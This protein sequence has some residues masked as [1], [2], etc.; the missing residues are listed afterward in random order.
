VGWG[1][2]YGAAAHSGRRGRRAVATTF[3]AVYT[4][5]DL[6]NTALGLYRP[7]E[8]VRQDTAIDVIDKLVQAAATGAVFDAMRGRSPAT[9]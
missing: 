8:W 1:A 7:L 9:A 4:G 6:L 3:A 2:A 5:D